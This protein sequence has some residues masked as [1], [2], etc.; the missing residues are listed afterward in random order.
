MIKKKRSSLFYIFILSIIISSI[1]LLIYGLQDTLILMTFTQ[2]ST[3][4][5]LILILFNVWSYLGVILLG[6]YSIYLL[7]KKQ[8]NAIGISKFYL[9]FIPFIP[10][11]VSAFF[12]DITG[13]DVMQ[14]STFTVNILIYSLI[15]LMYLITAKDINDNYPKQRRKMLLM[16]KFLLTFIAITPLLLYI[17]LIV[18]TTN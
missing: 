9:I 17:F 18:I 12:R 11:I 5:Y 6:I 16:D 1:I 3:L 7:I 10:S 4:N 15:G 8:S 13:K 2:L 14:I